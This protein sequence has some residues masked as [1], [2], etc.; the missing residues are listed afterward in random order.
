MALIINELA[1]NAFKHGADEP[2]VSIVVRE[3]PTMVNIEIRN[4]GRLPAGVDPLHNPG[5]S[6][7]LGLVLS[8]LPKKHV[9]LVIRN[10]DHG[11]VVAELSIDRETLALVEGDPVVS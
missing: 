2:Q 3:S 11:A 4:R 6:R 5:A 8:L 9:S 7:G 10:D 1:T